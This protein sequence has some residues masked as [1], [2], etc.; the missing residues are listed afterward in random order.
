MKITFKTSLFCPK[1]AKHYNRHRKDF[2]EIH[3]HFDKM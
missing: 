3:D 1:K 2:P